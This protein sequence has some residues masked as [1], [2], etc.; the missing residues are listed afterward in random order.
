MLLNVTNQIT[1]ACSGTKNRYFPTLTELDRL[2]QRTASDQFPLN[3]SKILTQFSLA[4][5]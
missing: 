2:G 4:V 1:S 5:F 3:G